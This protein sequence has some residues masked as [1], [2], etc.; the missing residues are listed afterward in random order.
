[1]NGNEVVFSQSGDKLI[2]R[3][4]DCTD[5]LL[6]SSHCKI[7]GQS[8]NQGNVVHWIDLGDRIMT[9]KVLCALHHNYT[10]KKLFPYIGSHPTQMEIKDYFQ[11][12]KFLKCTR[13]I[14]AVE[15][16][17]MKKNKIEKQG[18]E[19][20]DVVPFRYWMATLSIPKLQNDIDIIRL[21]ANRKM[22]AVDLIRRS[23]AAETQNYTK[24]ILKK[25]NQDEDLKVENKTTYTTTVKS[26][27]E[28]MM[29]ERALQQLLEDEEKEKQKA[30]KN[31]QTKSRKKKNKQT[32]QSKTQK[33][34]QILEVPPAIITT[35]TIPPCS[36]N[37][38]IEEPLDQENALMWMNKRF[39][40]ALR[41]PKTIIF[42]L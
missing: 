32:R 9:F 12:L 31:N 34:V 18:R 16:L 15:E 38:N 27:K 30:L 20:E 14:A 4:S 35:P 21:V 11:E 7:V 13:L 6:S 23:C 10:L 24:T 17:I 33:A 3:L 39:E 29:R 41:D 2:C 26:K 22:S 25:S 19:K 40:E 28:H 1:M 8:Y 5:A 37:V 36:S 42:H